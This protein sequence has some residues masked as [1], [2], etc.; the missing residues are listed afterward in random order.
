M[1]DRKKNDDRIVAFMR[2]HIDGYEKEMEGDDRTLIGVVVMV[3]ASGGYSIF[4]AVLSE[5]LPADVYLA[6]GLLDQ[7]KLDILASIPSNRPLREPDAEDVDSV[8][9]PSDPTITKPKD[10]IN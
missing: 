7:A 4:P 6:C 9:P 2:D 1:E 8:A 3:N 5:S 10:E